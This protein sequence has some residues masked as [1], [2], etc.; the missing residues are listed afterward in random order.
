MPFGFSAYPVGLNPAAVRYQNSLND[1][2]QP[3]PIAE[4]VDQASLDPGERRLPIS[5]FPHP[6][7]LLFS[8]LFYLLPLLILTGF[9]GWSLLTPTA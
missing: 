4:L 6:G 9:I 1:D 2:G 3:R 8:L 7:I 5:R